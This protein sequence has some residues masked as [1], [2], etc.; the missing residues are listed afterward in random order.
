M[1][2]V[3]RARLW[4]VG[5]CCAQ[6][7]LKYT[8]VEYFR[9][10]ARITAMARSKSYLLTGDSNGDIV[11]WNFFVRAT[12]WRVLAE[13]ASDRLFDLCVVMCLRQTA[14]RIWNVVAVGEV[15]ELQIFEHSGQEFVVSYHKL[16]DTN[17][18]LLDGR[19]RVWNAQVR[20][21]ADALLLRDRASARAVSSGA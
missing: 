8:G 9:G 17:G 5:L 7:G 2:H 13:R 14:E 3:R 12:S 1:L 16:L 20:V 10:S 15:T 4:C 21:L 18:V 19:L 6:D 11:A